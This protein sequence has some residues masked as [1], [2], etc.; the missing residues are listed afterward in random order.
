MN[1]IINKGTYTLYD[2][3]LFSREISPPSFVNACANA[4]TL[5]W[6]RDD[7]SAWPPGSKT[8][9]KFIAV[10]LFYS[11]S[12]AA[13]MAQQPGIQSRKHNVP[14][15]EHVLYIIMVFQWMLALSW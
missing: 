3:F 10:Q 14:R 9:K 2:T 11:P 4:F 6:R 15:K 1:H 5:I 8:S 12:S 13:A 7:G